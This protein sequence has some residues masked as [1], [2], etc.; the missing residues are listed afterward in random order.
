MKH[1]VRINCQFLINIVFSE[2]FLTPV[3]FVNL[4][5]ALRMIIGNPVTVLECQMSVFP[6]LCFLKHHKN[7]WSSISG[8]YFKGQITTIIMFCV[9]VMTLNSILILELWGEGFISLLLSL[10]MIVPVRVQSVGQT[11][12]FEII[13]KITV[14]LINTLAL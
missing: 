4:C 7:W 3:W 8:F 11:E 9:F 6:L 12:M 1:T 13:F 10:L 2:S 14:N 5:N